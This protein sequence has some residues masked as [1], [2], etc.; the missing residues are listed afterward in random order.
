MH[1]RSVFILM[2]CLSTMLIGQHRTSVH[3]EPLGNTSLQERIQENAGQ[4]LTAANVAYKEG[5][6]PTITSGVLTNSGE[7]ALQAIWSTS[8]FFCEDAELITRALQRPGGGYEIRNLPLALREAGSDELKY[9]EGVLIFTPSGMIE[10]LYFGL[11][12]QR[13][14][15]LLNEGNSVTEFRR[16]QIILDFIENYRTAYNRKDVGYIDNV[17][18]DNA[19]II[20]GTVL[21]VKENSA[22]FMTSN[23]GQKTVKYMRYNKGQYLDQLK[24]V[25]KNNE[26]IHVG[27]QE[28]EIFKHPVHERIYGV[29]LLQSWDS[30]SYSDV[31]YLFLLVDFQDES[32]PLIHV[33]TWQPGKFVTRD[34][35]FSL[36]DF[37][38]IE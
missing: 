28:I 23:L 31:G 30:S 7:T 15:Q 2:L 8:P 32:N 35:V 25:F 16:R 38:I 18:S 21:Q 27:F 34:Q 29:T 6:A 36:G 26:I 10:N 24:R 33:R 14:A 5:S 1:L 17:F 22:E 20:V 13:Y 12:N 3:L 19:L 9:E 11:S 4:F 37:E